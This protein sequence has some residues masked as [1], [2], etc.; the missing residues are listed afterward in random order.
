MQKGYRTEVMVTMQQKSKAH[1]TGSG[2]WEE[3][4]GSAI[5]VGR[6]SNKGGLKTPIGRCDHR[7]ICCCTALLR[8]VLAIIRTEE[9]DH[10]YGGIRRRRWQAFLT[11]VITFS[12]QLHI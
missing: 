12:P 6:G 4:P 1:R 9:E 8:P 3:G 11:I 5:T 7:P 10:E 2:R